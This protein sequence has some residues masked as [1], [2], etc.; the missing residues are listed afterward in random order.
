MRFLSDHATFAPW[1]AFVTS[2][3]ESASFLATSAHTILE[4]PVA[5]T[6]AGISPCYFAV[7]VVEDMLVAVVPGAVV[8]VG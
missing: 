4:L 7:V 2:G 1:P 3:F 8:A 5:L 6:N